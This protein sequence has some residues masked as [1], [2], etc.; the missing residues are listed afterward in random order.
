MTKNSLVCLSSIT[1][2]DTTIEG[3]TAWAEIIVTQTDGHISHFKIVNTYE[4]DLE[5]SHLPFLR[6]AFCMPL[7][8]YGLF[9]KKFL[10][11]FPVSKSVFSLLN[12]LNVIFSRDI[13]VN[14]I[15]DGTNP[16]ILSEFFP[17]P[18]KI[19]KKDGDP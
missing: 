14:K 17:D 6:L 12:D 4:N 5:A 2:S 10:L 13:F 3:K 18:K 19:T 8:N 1:L 11:Q 15:A 7:L 16:Y 9:T